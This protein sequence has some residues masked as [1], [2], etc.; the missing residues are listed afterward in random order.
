M[1]TGSREHCILPKAMDEVTSLVQRPTD[2]ICGM[3]RGASTQ[4]DHKRQ[5]LPEEIFRLSPTYA[6]AARSHGVLR[7]SCL[8]LWPRGV[9]YSEALISE[10]WG[11][12]ETLLR[13]AMQ[14][15]IVVAHY[16]RGLWQAI[17]VFSVPG[18]C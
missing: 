6:T 16:A 13:F 8:K 12:S 10:S 14:A 11:F 15:R 2:L 17:S 4:A 18:I 1:K 5:W 9:H 7:M 3:R